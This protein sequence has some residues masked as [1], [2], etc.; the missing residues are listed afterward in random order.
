MS[1]VRIGIDAD[2]SVFDAMRM[3]VSIGATLRSEHG[4]LVITRRGVPAQPQ[5]HDSPSAVV[6]PLAGRRHE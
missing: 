6:V 4:R 2:I 5:A 1:R 3:A